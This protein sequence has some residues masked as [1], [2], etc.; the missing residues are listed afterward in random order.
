MRLAGEGDDDFGVREAAAE[1][2]AEPLDG[3]AETQP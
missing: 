1:V 3:R 2:L